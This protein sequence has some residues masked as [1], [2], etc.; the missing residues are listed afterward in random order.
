MDQKKSYEEY[1]RLGK[2]LLLKVNC[3]QAQIAFYATQVCTI[4]HGGRSG[5]LYTLKKYAQDIGMNG[6]T[7][8][9]WVGVY[10]T[11]I[12]KLGMA[13][14]DV[15]QKDWTVAQRVFFILESESKATQALAG[16]PKNKGW[17]KFVPTKTVKD[18]FKKN[19][20]SHTLQNQIH[21]W[22]DTVIFIK[23][24]LVIRDLNEASTSSLLSLKE[25]LD[26]ASDTILRHVTRTKN[27]TE[28]TAA[29]KQQ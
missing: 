22:T 19:Y 24:K 17:R 8:S 14:E 7:L 12:E 9:G 10:R 15:T 28:L 20:D 18:L 3:Y 11:V 6:K 26:K 2:G 1:V 25:N 29:T 5:D 4:R 21:Q 27:I 23:N 16:I 13:P